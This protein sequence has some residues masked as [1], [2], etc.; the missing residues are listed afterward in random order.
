MIVLGTIAGFINN[1]SSHNIKQDIQKMLDI[2]SYRGHDLQEVHMFQEGCGLGQATTFITPESPMRKA[3]YKIFGKNYYISFDGRLDYRRDLCKKLNI[4]ETLDITDT[5]LV[6]L[7]YALYGEKFLNM[8]EGDFAFAIWDEENARLIL[9]RDRAGNRNLYYYTN[10]E[11]LIWASEIKQILLH[12]EVPRNL[13][14]RYIERFLLDNPRAYEETVYKSILR[15]KA[16]YFLIYDKRGINVNPYYT[17]TPKCIKSIRQS[18]IFEE[19]RE[20]FIKTV[21]NHLRSNGSVGIS[22]SGGLDSTSVFS[23]ASILKQSKN[24]LERIKVYS[25]VFR[26]NPSENEQEYI[27]IALN[28]YPTEYEFFNGDNEWNFKGF[29]EYVGDLDEPYP[30]FN[31]E[32]AMKIPKALFKDGIRVYLNGMYGDEVLYGNLYYLAGLLRKGSYLQLIREIRRWKN[33]IPIWDLIFNYTINPKF[34]Q[35]S[36]FIAPW[37]IKKNIDQDLLY[38][39]LSYTYSDFKWTEEEIVEY[40]NFLIFG[41]GHEW[42]NQYINSKNGID[43]RVPFRDIK[44]MEFLAG[45]PITIKI[46]PEYDKVIL[47][48]AM[49]NIL[50]EQIRTRKNKGAHLSFILNGF[51]KEWNQI[52]K[53]YSCPTLT[54]LGLVDNKPIIDLLEK[55]YAGMFVDFKYHS[56]LMRVLALEI[57][58]RS[59]INQL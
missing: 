56:S 46:D 41:T 16:G 10:G 34:S 18:D 12:S 31:Y 36:E 29:L 21:E 44:I 11:T 42:T 3:H 48:E 17:F 54:E 13:N 59:R 6:V 37:I 25:Y 24:S 8:L 22:L 19:F 40:F 43:V 52:K 33:K 57:W 58:L 20:L 27:N 47:R 2:V 15:L 51:K 53:Y 4:N 39:R 7:S 9:A 30:L 14:R 38:E 45:T 55:Y 1:Y 50:P 49:R 23:V 32:F 28:K 26:D 35:S 5:Y